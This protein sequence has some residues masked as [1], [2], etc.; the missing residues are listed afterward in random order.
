MGCKLQVCDTIQV[1]KTWLEV[2]LW[3]SCIFT[4]TGTKYRFGTAFMKPEMEVT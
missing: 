3:T 1:G 4:I 2:F